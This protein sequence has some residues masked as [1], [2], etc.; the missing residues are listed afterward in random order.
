MSQGVICIGV[1][2]PLEADTIIDK[3]YR[4]GNWC[5][6]SREEYAKRFRRDL[7]P[8]RFVFI[9]PDAW[10]RAYLPRF[11]KHGASHTE[12]TNLVPEDIELLS[13]EAREDEEV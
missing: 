13:D 10:K 2:V 1:S 9:T 5:V 8:L 12:Q 4:D 7:P 11:G 3:I 6:L